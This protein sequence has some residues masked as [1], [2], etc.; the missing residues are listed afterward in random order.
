MAIQDA[1]VL[2]DCLR[3]PGEIE[4]G[5]RSYEKKREG[6]TAEIVNQSWWVGVMGQFENPVACALRNAFTRIMPPA[7][8]LKLLGRIFKQEMP[9]L[10]NPPV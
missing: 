5:L 8:S 10:P 9:T 1:V 2:A 3:N 6:K 7:L 4:A